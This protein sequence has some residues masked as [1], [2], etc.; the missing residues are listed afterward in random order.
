MCLDAHSVANRHD[1]HACIP[2]PCKSNLCRNPCFWRTG[3]GAQ[4]TPVVPKAPNIPATAYGTDGIGTRFS[5]PTIMVAD[6]QQC[7]GLTGACPAALQQPLTE[8]CHDE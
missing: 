6:G 7:G 5:T 1:R 3:A 2:S 4:G 8:P